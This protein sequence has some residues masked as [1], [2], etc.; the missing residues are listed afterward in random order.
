MALYVFAYGSLLFRPDFAHESAPRVAH[1]DGY[2][3]RFA[4]GSPDHRGTPERP[5]RVVTLV[6]D[7][8]GRC[9]GALYEVREENRDSVLAYLDHRERGG[10]ER[11]VVRATLREGAER[12]EAVT[13]IAGPEN[14]HWLGDAD[15]VER[16]AAHAHECEGP[17]GRNADYVRKLDAV[18]RELR[19]H[20]AHV[21]AVADALDRRAAGA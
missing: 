14:P 4:Q 15:D 6:R 19:V 21:R 17:S 13:W 11:A 9:E 18:L 3:R 16:V 2:A 12:Y 1:V 8:G 20:D 5:G 10:Y 7:P